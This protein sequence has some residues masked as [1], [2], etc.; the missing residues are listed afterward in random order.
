VK[1]VLLVVRAED[2]CANRMPPAH[3]RFARPQVR[4]PLLR[5]DERF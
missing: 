2:K 4:F 3:E 1:T 5:A